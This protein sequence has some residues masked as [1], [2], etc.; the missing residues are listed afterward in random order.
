MSDQLSEIS[1]QLAA[2]YAE[3]ADILLGVDIQALKRKIR[4]DIRLLKAVLSVQRASKKRRSAILPQEPVLNGVH[5]RVHGGKEHDDLLPPM[6]NE[7]YEKMTNEE[8]ILMALG[9]GGEQSARDI[10]DWARQRKKLVSRSSIVAT[11]SNLKSK[12]ILVVSRTVQPE[13]GN[14]YS[15]YKKADNDGSH[16]PRGGV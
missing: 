16:M 10:I 8:L 7:Q 14:V 4:R 12:G 1:D 15:V 13:V 2:R 3:F 6:W 9:D 5:R 11:I